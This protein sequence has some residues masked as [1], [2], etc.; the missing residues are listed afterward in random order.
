MQLWDWLQSTGLAAWIRESLWAYPAVLSAHA[1]GMAIVVGIVLMI[2]FRALGFAAHIPMGAFDRL[3]VVARIGIILN[4]ASGVLLFITDA[5]QF[6]V[7][8]AFRIKLLL[9]VAGA[10]SAWLLLATAEANERI[11]SP[12][13][14][15]VALLSVLFWLG[16]ITAGRL[17]A[18]V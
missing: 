5:A 7:N 9:L 13:T 11:A 18:Y 3:M 12:R 4:V 8:T 6:A 17:T 2:D 10:I 15:V 16:A 1:I 14:K